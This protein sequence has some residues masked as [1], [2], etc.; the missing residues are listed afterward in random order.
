MEANMFYIH[1]RIIKKGTLVK[2]YFEG[3]LFVGTLEDADE[4]RN[5]VQIKSASG[6]KKWYHESLISFKFF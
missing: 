4:D 3:K 5:V 2:A 6:E 1:D